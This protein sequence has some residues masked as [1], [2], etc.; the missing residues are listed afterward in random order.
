M[1]SLVPSIHATVD[2]LRNGISVTNTSRS[3]MNA[4]QFNPDTFTSL[5]TTSYRS[6]LGHSVTF[7]L[8]AK[9]QYISY[10]RFY[11]VMENFILFLPVSQ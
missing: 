9:T 3:F 4:T 6:L 11:M 10:I 5:L 8:D 1:A 2:R 7:F